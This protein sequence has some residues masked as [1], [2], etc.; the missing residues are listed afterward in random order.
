MS[1]HDYTPGGRTFSWLYGLAAGVALFSGFGQMPIFKRY[2]L[3]DLPLM[4]WAA[5]F[6]ILSD[7]HYLAAALLLALLAWRLAGSQGIF[8]QR[9]SWGPRS[10]W[11]WT[12]LG[13]LILSG[14]FKVARNAGL[15]LPPLYLM[16]LDFVHLGSAMAYIFTGL[17]S[18]IKGRKEPSLALK[19]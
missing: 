1:A 6:Y 16:I 15:F 10:W 19:T 7:L 3:A 8:D 18:L 2:Y 12:L 4:G 14:A 11:G 5:D 9:W 13:L 17:A